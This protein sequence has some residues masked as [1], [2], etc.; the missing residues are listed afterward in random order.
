MEPTIMDNT[1]RTVAEGLRAILDESY[2]PDWMLNPL[3]R[4][5]E[6]VDPERLGKR[7]LSMMNF[8]TCSAFGDGGHY[9]KLDRPETTD[10][11]ELGLIDYGLRDLRK[12]GPFMANFTTAGEV[13]VNNGEYDTDLLLQTITVG[14]TDAMVGEQVTIIGDAAL[15]VF[16]LEEMYKDGI[17]SNIWKFDMDGEDV[18]LGAIQHEHVQLS[19]ILNLSKVRQLNQTVE[20]VQPRQ[21]H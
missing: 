15:W 14:T 11:G 19:L 3:L 1:E 20:T 6:R 8:R 4:A 2:L 21:L 12:C 13:P 9:V 18:I 10:K 7:F 16:W 5:L 17:S